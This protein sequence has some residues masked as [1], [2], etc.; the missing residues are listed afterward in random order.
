MSEIDKQLDMERA[1]RVTSETLYSADNAIP[2][3]WLFEY[4]DK[5]FPETVMSPSYNTLT[6]M[7]HD[8]CRE[9][10]G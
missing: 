5:H 8:Y 6:R 2:F 10:F 1:Q 9:H 7:F 3:K 4:M